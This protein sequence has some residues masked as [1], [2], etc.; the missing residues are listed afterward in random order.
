M[1]KKELYEIYNNINAGATATETRGKLLHVNYC[2]TKK[3]AAELVTFWRQCHK[4]NGTALFNG[5]F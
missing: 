1:Y 4:E 3:Q 2:E 5:R